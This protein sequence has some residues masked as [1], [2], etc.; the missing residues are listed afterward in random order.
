MPALSAARDLSMSPQQ[1]MLD[2]EAIK[3][4]PGLAGY[5]P[6]DPAYIYQDLS[7]IHI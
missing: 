6:A 1:A 4:I 5:W 2:W 7:L 3:R